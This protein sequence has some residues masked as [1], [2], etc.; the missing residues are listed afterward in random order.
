MPSMIM[1]LISEMFHSRFLSSLPQILLN[2][3]MLLHYWEHHSSRGP[4]AVQ[5]AI[6]ANLK[7]NIN[8]TSIY[9]PEKNGY[10][11]SPA[12]VSL[13]SVSS[14][15]DTEDSNDLGSHFW[16]RLKSS[17]SKDVLKSR[18]VI[19]TWIL[20]ELEHVCIQFAAPTER[21]VVSV[22]FGGKISWA[23][24]TH[25]RIE[26]TAVVLRMSLRPGK[27]RSEMGGLL[28]T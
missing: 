3:F 10:L 1:F 23:G 7:F 9:G 19:V 21:W 28:S 4:V 6:V 5:R 8:F 24:A 26:W 18:S 22:S 25:S 27:A 11:T 2:M 13:H 20:Q 17:P 14:R 16:S 15:S 12:E